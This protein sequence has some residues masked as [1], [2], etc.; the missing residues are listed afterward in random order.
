MVIDMSYFIRLF[1]VSF[2]LFG[3][4][5]QA[6]ELNFSYAKNKQ[7][8]IA[9]NTCLYGRKNK[10]S[11][12]Q[13]SIKQIQNYV[14]QQPSNFENQIKSINTGMLGR[15]LEHA[16]LAYRLPKLHCAI[17]LCKMERR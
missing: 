3:A 2:L 13:S 1:A 10:E 4:K 17:A 5:T 14:L 16:K 9:G 7:L 12:Q 15:R 11:I 8:T 6:N